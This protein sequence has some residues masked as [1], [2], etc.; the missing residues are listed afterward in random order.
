MNW[1]RL[2][3]FILTASAGASA[4]GVSPHDGAVSSCSPSYNG[5]FEVTISKLGKRDIEKRSCGGSD[6]LQLTLNGNI[7]KDAKDRTGYIASNYQFQFDDPTQPDSLYTSGFS[8]CSNGSL[9]LR[10]S[11]VF[12][13][14]RSGTF[15]NLYDRNWAAQCEPIEILIMPCD[16]NTGGNRANGGADVIVGTKVVQTTIVKVLLDG[17]PQVHATSIAMPICQLGDGQPQVREGPCNGESPASPTGGQVPPKAASTK[18]PTAI[19]T[20]T[21]SPK[22]PATHVPEGKPQAPPAGTGSVP[23]PPPSASPETPVSGAATL[24]S[25]VQVTMG[26]LMLYYMGVGI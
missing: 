16:G 11:T 5:K 8:A 24:F 7:L 25:N 20:A 13:Q 14:C 17:Q 26:I 2:A 22:P 4:H 19:P 12:Y 10:G 18:P 23:K 3:A 15:Y 9:A 21:G 6:A 1:I